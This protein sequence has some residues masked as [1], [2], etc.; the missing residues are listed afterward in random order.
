MF[1]AHAEKEVPFWQGSTDLT[2]L[3]TGACLPGQAIST[4]ELLAHIDSTFDVDVAHRGRV[5]AKKLN[6]QQRFLSRD[7]LTQCEAPRVGH[8]NPEL[9]ADA[10]RAAL[11]DA[12]LNVD[13]LGYLIG[14]TA[15]PAMPVP[16]NISFVADN[17]AFSGPHMELR[18]ACTGFANALVIAEGLLSNPDAKPVAIVG[19]ET[20]SVF[21]NP[22]R[23]KD[24]SGQL[25]NMVQMGDA[26]AAIILCPAGSKYN[27][28]AKSTGTLS[29]NFYGQIGLQREPGFSLDSGGSNQPVSPTG[30]P[31]FSH[32]FADVRTNGPELFMAGLKAAA[33]CGLSVDNMDY[34]LPH[35]ANGLMGILMEQHL[36]VPQSKVVVNADTVGNTGSAAIWLAFS[37]MRNSMQCGEKLLTLGA[38]AT[39]YMFGG[40][41]YTHGKQGPYVAK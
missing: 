5:Y 29:K 37:S 23:L 3:G 26:A 34:I 40:F 24:D 33:Q 7:L 13:D 27:K 10:V 6:I 20:G 17:L 19:S 15:T 35:Q 30:M 11:A 21:F 1:D 8:R 25:V 4:E 28:A 22:D 38:E 12:G 31:E 32:A 41:L 39:K 36:G 18:Q 14:H 16:S 9:A 2:V